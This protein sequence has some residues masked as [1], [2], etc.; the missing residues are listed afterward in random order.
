MV[1][2][3]LEQIFKP[4]WIERKEHAFFLALFYSF[5]GIISAK[6]IFPAS[7]GLMS[8]AFTSL[9]LIPSLN[10]LLMMEENTEIRENK[11]SL[12]L[13]FRDH[14]DI[15]KVYIFMFLGVFLAFSIVSMAMSAESKVL[16][17]PQLNSAGFSG[18]AITPDILGEIIFNNMLVFLVCFILSFVYGAG[19][20]IFLTWNAS[21]WGSVVGIV[22]LQASRASGTS[23]FFEMASFIIPFLPHMITEALA[24][25]SAAI[26]GGVVSKAV[27]REKLFSRKFHHIVTDALLFL[28]IGLML[29]I[30]AGIIEIEFFARL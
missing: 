4:Q 10:L 2:V 12:L 19:S 29:V 22:V 27:I 11:F 7:F 26:V 25:I 28:M 17:E 14:K 9:L 8:V 18:F 6:L 21:V 16:F 1:F 15:F 23:P 3:V 30:L 13:L 5:V 20:V 24:Y